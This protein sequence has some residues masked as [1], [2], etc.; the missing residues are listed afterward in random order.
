MARRE[1]NCCSQCG[2]ADRV[3]SRSVSAGLDSG[4]DA[5]LDWNHVV[6]L[7]REL[8]LSHAAADR[9]FATR[10]LDVLADQS[11]PC[12][13]SSRDIV[14][15]EWMDVIGAALDRCDWLAVVLTPASV[16]SEWVKEEV[17]YWFRHSQHKEN[18]VP[19]L[20]SACEPQRLAF[21]LS[22]FQHVDFT[23][24]FNEACRELLRRWAIGLKHSP[25]RDTARPHV[26]PP[27]ATLSIEAG[28]RADAE[29]IATACPTAYIGSQ[30]QSIGTIS[31]IEHAAGALGTAGTRLRLRLEDA[32]GPEARTDSFTSPAWL[33]VTAGDIMIEVPSTGRAGTA[34]AGLWDGDQSLLEW[35]L[36]SSSTVASV[37]QVVGGTPE[38]PQP[39]GAINGP[40]V[41]L[42]AGRVPGPVRAIIELLPGIDSTPLVVG[43]VEVAH[44]AFKAA[45]AIATA[46]SAP[47]VLR[48][49]EALG[50]AISV[51]Y[52]LPPGPDADLVAL[53]VETPGVTITVDGNKRPQASGNAGVARVAWLDERWSPTH[54]ELRLSGRDGPALPSITISNIHYHVAPT[55]PTGVPVVLKVECR[56][57]YGRPF[58]SYVTNAIVPP[59]ESPRDDPGG[60]RRSPIG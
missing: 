54:L 6:K 36:Y 55:A 29:V 45:R 51:A 31:I 32:D 22:G 15:G 53:D 50:G 14:Q 19:I 34:V 58:V 18:V 43:S 35:R 52:L 30:G 56:D 23:R 27:G 1:I 57:R 38:G 60:T 9:E 41:D 20:L 11:I 44:A 13:Y 24:D 21:P 40:R 25:D 59:L 3:L 16:E 28:Q 49:A 48:G 39:I 10:L 17:Q 5:L 46:T 33:V 26:G 37:L 4:R 7:P 42:H 12:F 47:D 2:A 8:F